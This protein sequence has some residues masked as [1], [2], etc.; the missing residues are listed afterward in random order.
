MVNISFDPNH[1]P[2]QCSEEDSFRQIT[3]LEITAPRTSPA[4]THLTRTKLIEDLRRNLHELSS[5]N[6]FLP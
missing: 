6:I 4:S 3:C 1:P 5:Q 2:E